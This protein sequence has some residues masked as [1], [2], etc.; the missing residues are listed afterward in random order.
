MDLEFAKNEKTPENFPIKTEKD[1]DLYAYRVAGTVAEMVLELIFSHSALNISPAQRKQ[2][3]SSGGQMGRA[4]QYTNIGRDMAVDATINR[5]YIPST[6]L[7]EQ[8]LVVDDLLRTS[9]ATEEILAKF[10]ARVIDMAFE[11]YE[12]NRANME[13]LPSEGRGPIRV[14]IESYMEIGRVLQE[15]GPNYRNIA[16]KA[17]V[18]PMRRITTAWNAMAKGRQGPV[19]MSRHFAN[20]NGTLVQQKRKSAIVVGKIE[21]GIEYYPISNFVQVLALV[22]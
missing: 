4:L 10:R 19:L 3:V 15:K 9:A 12:A 8:G 17:T 5:V 2:L 13:L 6:W 7:K 22:E 14:A 11:I 20:T 21:L 1:L 16:G 18:P